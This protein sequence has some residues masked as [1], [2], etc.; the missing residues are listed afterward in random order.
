M[1]SIPWYA[2]RPLVALAPMEGVTD[3]PY[4]RVCREL[5]PEAV[6]FTE[7]TS[8]QGLLHGNERTWGM[9]RFAE[10]ERPIVVQL[11]GGEPGALAAAARAVE[12]QVRPDGIDLNLGC[13]VKKVL[14]RGEGCALMKDPARAREIVQAMKEAIRVPLS[15]KMRLGWES[16]EEAVPFACLLAEAGVEAL[17]VHG[18]LRRDRPRHPADWEAIARVKASLGIPVIGNG[19]IVS[20]EET[21]RRQRESGVDGVMIARGAM[22]NPWLLAEARA[23]LA[24]EPIPAPPTLAERARVAARHLD[25]NIERHGERRGVLIMRKHYSSYLGGF[26]GA[27]E[28]RQRLVRAATRDEVLALLAPLRTGS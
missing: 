17:T 5:A 2:R 6:L 26:P 21:A 22:G 24:G 3:G 15:A 13:P 4:R 27:R 7:F 1:T 28:L 18:R 12:E 10:Q 8:A 19:D 20:G 11:Y 9:A 23:A 25:L 14:A 16:R